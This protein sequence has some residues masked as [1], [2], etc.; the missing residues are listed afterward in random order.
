MTFQEGMA[1]KKK[2]SRWYHHLFNNTINGIL[3]EL[4]I[5]FQDSLEED[6]EQRMTIRVAMAE[7]VNS[8][9]S[10]SSTDGVEWTVRPN[11][12]SVIYPEVLQVLG[13]ILDLGTPAIQTIPE[14]FKE[15]MRD[16]GRELSTVEFFRFRQ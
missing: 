2:F 6:I 5:N 1:E 9:L 14:I 4:Y 12:A 7:I 10:C 3:M 16:S 11:P 15:K 8:Y 13:T